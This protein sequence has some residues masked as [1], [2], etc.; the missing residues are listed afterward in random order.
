MVPHGPFLYVQLH[1]CESQIT[2]VSTW[3]AY[4]LGSRQ[5]WWWRVR[6]R[7]GPSCHIL[8]STYGRDGKARGLCCSLHDTGGFG[9][10]CRGV[11]W[12]GSCGSLWESWGDGTEEQLILV[13][14][15]CPLASRHSTWIC[16]TMLRSWTRNSFASLALSD[17]PFRAWE[18]W[19]CR[20]KKKRSLP[21]PGL[22]LVLEELIWC[23]LGWG[24]TA[25][26]HSLLGRAA[27]SP[28]P[29]G[30]CALSEER[31]RSV[32]LEKRIFSVH[33]CHGPPW[34]TRAKPPPPWVSQ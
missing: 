30:P 27:S 34:G 22:N 14:R 10:G 28:P 6:N 19:L 4:T 25:A 13:G 21:C 23:D 15:G 33:L 20:G 3:D 1:H 2:S 16:C 7:F 31:K 18:S 32:K 9:E 12:E 29:R 24:W 8:A 11:I 5:I 26:R 17:K